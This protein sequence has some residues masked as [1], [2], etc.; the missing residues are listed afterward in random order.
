[1]SSYLPVDW[2]DWPRGAWLD[3]DHYMLCV[4]HFHPDEASGRATGVSWTWEIRFDGAI[5]TFRS[6]AL[7]NSTTKTTKSA[8]VVLFARPY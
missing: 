1:M 6:K 4:L 3:W 7:V 5:I 8:A 2:D